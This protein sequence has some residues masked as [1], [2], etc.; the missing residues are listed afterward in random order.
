VLRHLQEGFQYYILHRTGAIQNDIVDTDSVAASERLG[1]YANAYRLRLLEVLE[2]DFVALCAFL[3]RDEFNQI[4]HAYID[5][6]PSG[7]F[8]LRHFGRHL[9][10][11]LGAS[12]PYKDNPLLSELATFDWALT[13]AFDVENSS[14]ATVE[15][16]SA[17]PPDTWPT[18]RFVPHASFR[19]LDLR[20]N[21]PAIWK[22]ADQRL[23][24]L[25]KPV[26]AD[27]PVA[28]VV[29]RQ[30]LDSYFRSLA[31]DEAWALDAMARGV[32]FADLCE[33]LCEWIDA[34]NVA[35]HAAG[36]LKQWLAD[37]LIKEIH[38]CGTTRK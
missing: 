2:A 9:S 18:A 3:G 23:E 26:Q 20:W 21:A 24:I 35:V 32:S 14:V 4:G 1:I 13:E 37:G 33:G 30:H 27:Q 10:R 31:V 25:P 29:W 19:R 7:H 11:F 6:H 17:I 5:A 28:W 34:Q 36:L 22:A 38:A 15:E 12:P 8:S 16:M